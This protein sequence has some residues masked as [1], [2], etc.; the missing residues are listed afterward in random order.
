M[1]FDG[2]DDAARDSMELADRTMDRMIQLVD[3]DREM[4]IRNAEAYAWT[5]ANFILLEYRKKAAIEVPTPEPP[6]PVPP[7][8]DPLLICLRGCL[9]KLSSSDRNLILE[10][11]A[12]DKEM[13]ITNR[14][15]IAAV[16]GLSENALH[17]RA[18][19]IRRSLEAC[20]ERAMKSAFSGNVFE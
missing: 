18:H 1:F 19:R 10:Y 6:A 13:K 2:H 12:D 4:V 14:R 5:V 20:I 8:E 9:A 15:K 17:V 16:F 3:R 7:R 11:Y